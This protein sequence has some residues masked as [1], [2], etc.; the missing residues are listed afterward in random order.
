[1]CQVTILID[2]HGSAEAA[3][4]TI[5]SVIGQTFRDWELIVTDHGR[6]A[7]IAE[8]V[9][10]DAR[11]RT[12]RPGVGAETTPSSDHGLVCYLQ[13]GDLWLPHMLERQVYLAHRAP[14]AVSATSY[15]RVGARFDAEASDWIPSG[16]VVRARSALRAPRR[17]ATASLPT[18]V[19]MVDPT[20][21]GTELPE[22]GRLIDAALAARLPVR[23]IDEALA[24]RRAR[25]SGLRGRCGTSAASGRDRSSKRRASWDLPA[26]VAART[27][28]SP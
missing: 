19:L 3:G 25:S 28:D 14:V 27:D 11:I 10:G 4:P 5:R 16:R 22:P 21:W 1:M 17:R 15:F 12:Q 9:A 18:S 2:I 6:S 24:L 7:R 23:G 13:E 26:L 8:V 20:R